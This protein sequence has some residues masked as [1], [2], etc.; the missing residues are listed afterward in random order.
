MSSSQIRDKSYSILVN[1]KGKY[2]L[3]EIIIIRDLN[4]KIGRER[5]SE[6]V[7]KYELCLCNENE[8]KLIYSK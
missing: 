7:D 2:K 1:A 4:S 3:Q 5:D 8:E 6:I